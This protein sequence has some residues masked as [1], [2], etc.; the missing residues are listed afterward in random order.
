MSEPTSAVKIVKTVVSDWDQKNKLSVECD[1]DFT[2]SNLAKCGIRMGKVEFV[3][4]D[5]KD[6][7]YTAKND[8]ITSIIKDEIQK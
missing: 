3:H 6:T 7:I 4:F 5:T 8:E 2:V 1:R